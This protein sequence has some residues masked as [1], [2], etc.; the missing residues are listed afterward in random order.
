M[1]SLNEQIE[2]LK[3]EKSTILASIG[4]KA[5]SIYPHYECSKCNDTGYILENRTNSDV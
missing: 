5:N 1:S 3:K 4:D 2:A